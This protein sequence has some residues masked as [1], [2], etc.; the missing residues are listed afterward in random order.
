LMDKRFDTV[1]FIGL[2]VMGGAMA[3][4]L[5]AA[6]YR[7]LVNTRT[8]AKAARLLEAGAVWR[9]SAARLAAESDVVITMVGYP[10]EVESLYFGPAGIIENARP[11]CVLVD[12]STS[13]PDLAVRI[14]AAARAR[15][16]KALDA[17]VSGGDSGARNA[18]LTIMVGGDSAVFEAVRPLFEA[19]GKTIVLQGGPGAGQHTKMANQ[20]AIAGSL[21]GA[22]ESIVYAEKAGLDPAKVLLSISTGSAGSWQL[23]NNGQKIL[24]AD[25]SPGFYVKHFRKDLGIAL[26][27]AKRMG[28]DLPLL[29]LAER[30]FTTMETKGLGD[31]GTQS[32]YRLYAGS[33][34]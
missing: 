26:D 27:S 15:G 13:S 10:S 24:A 21:C 29:A 25:F 32:L 5:Q 20:I 30:L 16:L 19:M 4:H 6:G 34:E 28:I 11:G 3:S 31:L 9:E 14:E 17:P 2:G 33:I 22:V 8:P 18:T 1:G 7:I 12:M 23:T